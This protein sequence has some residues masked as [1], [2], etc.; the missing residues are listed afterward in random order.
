MAGDL[1]RCEIERLDFPRSEGIW[2]FGGPGFQE[3]FGRFLRE[4]AVV[5]RAEGR[6]SEHPAWY[7]ALPDGV[8][9]P[10]AWE[11]GIRARSYQALLR[12]GVVP[13]PGTPGFAPLRI[14]DMGAGNG[15]LSARLAQLGHVPLAL[16]VSLD[17]R[18]GLGAARHHAVGFERAQADFEMMPLAPGAVDRAIWN[19]AFHYATDYATS[20]REVLRVLAPGGRIVVLDS[21]LYRD[22]A[23]GRQ[24]VGERRE[25][26]LRDHGF[27]PDPDARESFLT[28]RRLQD[29]G[30]E[31]GLVW[32]RLR[33]AY[34]ARWV[35]RR[36]K[37]RLMGRRELADMA[38]LI[39]W[40][41]SEAPGR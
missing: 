35:L 28:E 3:R 13:R 27:E 40:R 21:P 10:H 25:R 37:A 9:G 4:Y 14:V 30:R 12:C 29:L 1:L 20:L 32:N 15:W 18:D 19:G 2:R 16:D 6:G 7:R 31:L 26:F 38:L 11:W 36:L 5:R 39:G 33:P 41:R 22:A 23:S 24:M 17:E 8:R 34:G